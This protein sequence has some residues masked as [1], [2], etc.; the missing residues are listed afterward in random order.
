[1]FKKLSILAALALVALAGCNKT[2]TQT[3]VPVHV[4][5][6]DFT[7]ST[8]QFPGTKTAQDA[9]D[10]TDVKAITLAFYKND[11]TEQYK[12]TQLRADN[13]TYTTFGEFTL[14][15]PM[16]SY[17][18][19]V[20]GY[21][22]NTGEPAITL[23]SPTSATFGDYPA[24]ETFAYTQAVNITNTDEVDLSATLDRV[25]SKLHVKS[26][27]VRTSNASSVRLTFSK[28]G[29]SFNPTTGLT[30]VNNGFI[31]SLTITSAVG[32]VSKSNCYLFL[33]SDE[34]TMDVTIETLDADNNVLFSKTVQDVSFKR[35]RITILTGDIYTNSGVGA[36]FQLNTTWIDTHNVNF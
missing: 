15:L 11:G 2:Q 1:M 4:H 28:G 31:N 35:N 6:N 16:G 14:S 26:S 18:M 30:T 29:K 8:D 24:R 25:V 13:T 23:T 7:I 27:D 22:L 17:T 3:Q 21:G 33:A 19:V 5:V 36:S 10:Y 34:Q 20:L 32:E 9:A 12:V